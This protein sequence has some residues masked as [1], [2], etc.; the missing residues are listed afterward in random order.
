MYDEELKK[1][2]ISD[3][4]ICDNICKE[5][6]LIPFL[7][8]FDID[9]EEIGRLVWDSKQWT[10]KGNVAASAFLFFKCLQTFIDTHVRE[11]W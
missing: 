11:N 8:F 1:K 7:T 3:N 4:F 9:K 5:E 10:F 6:K 2:L